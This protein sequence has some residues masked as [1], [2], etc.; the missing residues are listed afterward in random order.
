MFLNTPWFALLTFTIALLPLFGSFR[1]VDRSGVAKS[2]GVG[3][4]VALLSL[5]PSVMLLTDFAS[6]NEYFKLRFSSQQIYS[7][8]D[9]E[10]GYYFINKFWSALGGDFYILRYFIILFFLG[11]NFH[12]FY[13]YS[14]YPWL[15]SLI[16]VALQF[17]PDSY[18]LR[19][20]IA[21]ALCLLSLVFW[22]RNFRYC[23]FLFLVL[24]CFFHYTGLVFLLVYIINAL[25]LNRIQYFMFLGLTYVLA[26]S[27]FASLALV[28]MA[29]LSDFELLA[30]RAGHYLDDDMS[31]SVGLIRGSVLIY[32]LIYFWFVIGMNFSSKVERLIA[33]TMLAGLL[34]LVGFS[35]VGVFSER[36]FRYFS[37]S[38]CVALC[39]A[40]RRV[41]NRNLRQMLL[42]LAPNLLFAISLAI[43]P[44]DIEFL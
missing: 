25:R 43:T 33:S 44:N 13:S 30:T 19:Q 14:P 2:V 7:V 39:I 23:A 36:L 24:S 8:F 15:A 32:T 38:F 17:Y 34:F 40:I 16:Y 26:L 21:G 1:G 5:I 42:G 28:A 37:I 20:S 3:V 9:F 6:Y 22:I 35:S 4:T 41:H 18:L 10:P 27:N 11:I 12:F 29:E 31:A